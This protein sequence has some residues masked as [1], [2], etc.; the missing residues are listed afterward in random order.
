MEPSAA[1]GF[2]TRLASWRGEASQELVACE[3]LPA[4]E[5]W[6]LRHLGPL[7]F[8]R[9]ATLGDIDRSQSVTASHDASHGQ[10]GGGQPAAAAAVPARNAADFVEAQPAEWHA[11]DVAGLVGRYTQLRPAGECSNASEWPVWTTR[12]PY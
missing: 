9:Q 1:T 2:D 10:G 6:R 12:L 11:S 7:V 4:L 8:T 3:A 5:A